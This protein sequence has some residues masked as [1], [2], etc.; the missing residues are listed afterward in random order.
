MGHYITREDSRGG[1]GGSS[2]GKTLPIKSRGAE[3][4]RLG[5]GKLAKVEEEV[6]SDNPKGD[7]FIVPVDIWYRRAYVDKNAQV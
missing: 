4:V 7:Y 5:R 6:V 2:L 1:Q 3:L